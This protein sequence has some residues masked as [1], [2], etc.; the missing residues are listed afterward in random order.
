MASIWDL[1]VD[2][3]HNA[4]GDD[5][6]LMEVLQKKVELIHD[7]SL[8][9]GQVMKSRGFELDIVSNRTFT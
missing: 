3:H 6:N 1:N 7:L 9:R 5:D 4:N 8:S 2:D